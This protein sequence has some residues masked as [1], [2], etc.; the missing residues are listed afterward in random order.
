MKKQIKKDE[1][2]FS[3]FK[4]FN[5]KN[6]KNI[7]QPVKIIP[8]SDKIRL[9]DKNIDEIVEICNQELVYELLFREK[10]NGEKYKRLNAK[11]FVTWA[12]KGWKESLYFVYL[13]RLKDGKI[14]GAIDI[15]SNNLDLGE[16]GYWMDINFPGYMTNIVFG[17]AQQAKRVG[18][19]KLVAYT[20]LENIKSKGVLERAGFDYSGQEKKEGNKT[21][22]KYIC[23]L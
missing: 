23:K 17:L 21:F 2:N 13:A 15:K 14:V 5:V 16:I 3:E 4:S 12:N 6:Y 1:I 9:T 20:K 11:S 8:V 18:F 22:D 7:L 10:L 19:R